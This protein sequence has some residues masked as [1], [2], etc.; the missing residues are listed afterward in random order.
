M[1]LNN[2]INRARVRK[3]KDARSSDVDL[4]GGCAWQHDCWPLVLDT[5]ANTVTPPPLFGLVWQWAEGDDGRYRRC[6]H[7]I[8]EQRMLDRESSKVSSLAFGVRVVST[9]YE[10][11]NLPSTIQTSEERAWLRL[12][13]EALIGAM[14]QNHIDGRLSPPR[15]PRDF[16]QDYPPH[17]LVCAG[18]DSMQDEWSLL[19]D[20]PVFRTHRFWSVDCS[21]GQHLIRWLFLQSYKTSSRMQRLVEVLV[22]LTLMV[23]EYEKKLSICVA[24][25]KKNEKRMHQLTHMAGPEAEE[26]R[27]QRGH[28]RNSW[29]NRGE[30]VSFELA[31]AR[32]GLAQMTAT[33]DLG[34][35]RRQ[36]TPLAE[37][38]WRE[39]TL[40]EKYNAE[41]DVHDFGGFPTA[42]TLPPVL[43]TTSPTQR[44]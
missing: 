11:G 6:G 37:E 10:L 22:R 17:R 42:D 31:L 33:F 9:G 34:V 39:F 14:R 35:F 27:F 3:L 13:A 41:A 25:F 21:F 29:H 32:H 20:A 15:M 44:M 8:Y 36:D 16:R 23:S 24:E 2:P 40:R 1:C 19:T 7:A 38:T 4:L 5:F 18:F 43:F 26:E 28:M 12:R 30:S